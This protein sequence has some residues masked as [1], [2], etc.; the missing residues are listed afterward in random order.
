VGQSKEEGITVTV[1]ANWGRKALKD[2]TTEKD[3]EEE[4]EEE[5]EEEQT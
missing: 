1:R 3:E 4:K 2:Y 5:E